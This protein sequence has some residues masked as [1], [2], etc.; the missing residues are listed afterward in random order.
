VELFLTEIA[1]R[2][3]I[4]RN[5]IYCKPKQAFRQEPHLLA[6]AQLSSI[7]FHKTISHYFFVNRQIC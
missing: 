3:L 1:V 5:P 7:Q 4:F 2:M 6:N